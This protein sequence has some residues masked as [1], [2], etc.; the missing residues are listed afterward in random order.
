MP[1]P[2]ITASLTYWSTRTPNAVAVE[3]DGATLTWRELADSV[4]SLAEHLAADG[5]RAG[6]RIGYLC[7]NSVGVIQTILAAVALDAIVV[8]LNIRLTI[9]ELSW[10]VEDAGLDALLVDE[11]YTRQAL[12]LRE[13][14]ELRLYWEGP[15]CPP[16][17]RPLVATPAGAPT[18][19][20]KR[21]VGDPDLPA[22][23]SYTSGTTGRPKGAILTH[24]NFLAAAIS[25]ATTESMTRHDSCLLVLPLAFT[26]SLM[27]TWAP[28]YYTGARFVMHPRFDA[29][30]T[31]TE[32][33]HGN[34]TVFPAVPV[35]FDQLA[36]LPRFDTA[37]LSTLR[38][39]KAGGAPPSAATLARYLRRGMPI[40]QG[41]GMTESTGVGA[42]LPQ[43]DFER[44]AGSTGVTNY[45]IE[46]AIMDAE[47][48]PLPD[49]EVG[50]ICL[51]G[52]A[53][54]LG[55]WRNPE[56]T[57]ETLRDGWLRTGDLGRL[58]HE[59]Y[60]TIMGREKDMVL[61]GG[62]NV[63]PGEIERIIMLDPRVSEAAVV[64]V[65]DERWGEVPAAVVVSDSADLT[66]AMVLDVCRLELADYKVPKYVYVRPEPLPRTM[67]GKVAKAEVR[68]ELSEHV[69]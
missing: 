63:Y 69:S 7:Q 68:A 29:A 26:G 46:L 16:W 19:R 12:E 9:P 28:T 24:G 48:T 38:V 59:G 22:F 14:R 45:G 62:L 54:M 51:R 49:D 11:T 25:F 53:V 15:G 2:R 52:A 50:E 41:Y 18:G 3:C 58:D 44:K 64:A 23:I 47:G 35:V 33:E 20:L 10:I 13:G 60:L 36:A 21:A 32:L 37:D 5:L 43:E 65:P 31:L 6:D 34:I 30:R 1:S 40:G 66:A 27:A 4:E 17:A 61:S 67:S 8:P 55:Y 42:S 39:A 56:A 57:A